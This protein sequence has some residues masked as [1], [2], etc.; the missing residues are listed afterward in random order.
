MFE[1]KDLTSLI[2]PVKVNELDRLLRE[3]NYD[4]HKRNFLVDGFSNRFEIGYRGNPNVKLSAPNL[5]LN[6]G[7]ELILWNKVMKEVEKCR[8]AG[9]FEDVPYA[10]YIQSPIGLVPKDNG[11]VR[12]IFHLSYPRRSKGG[13]QLSVNVNTP[14]EMCTVSYADFDSAVELCRKAG[15]SCSMAKSDF[16]SAFHQLCIRVSDWKFLIMKARCPLDGKFYYFVDKC[17]PFGAAISCAHFQRFLDAVAYI[18]K[19]RTGKT[20]INYL[21]DYFFVALLAT[22]CNGQ[23]E[24]FL[25]IC[26]IINFPVLLDKT[27]FATTRLVFLGLLL[28]SDLQLVMVPWDKVETGREL[29]EHMLS[30]KKTTLHDLQKLTGFLNFIGHA[31][32]PR[33]AFTHRL[34]SYTSGLLKPHHHIRMNAEMRADLNLWR[35]FLHHP[36]IY[37][38]PFADFATGINA[39][40]VDMYSDASRNWKL[41]FAATFQISWCYSQWDYE[42]LSTVEPSIEYLEL[43][44]VVTGVIKW[45]HRFAN[46]SYPVLQQSERCSH[47]KFNIF[48]L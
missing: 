6:V 35:K 21:D 36:S 40:E 46:K 11:K 4:E 14:H 9:P 28:N 27:V 31:I 15:V 45:I 44:A 23:V 29:V 2:T 41:G 8:Y 20:T 7:N 26:A 33:C 25:Q 47:D 18:F 42:F 37:S 10:N 48:Q 43:Y 39:T 5:K 30:K 24:E 1:N 34:Y 13:D 12:L 22:L 32:V 19:A 17:L 38:R 3:C 16:S